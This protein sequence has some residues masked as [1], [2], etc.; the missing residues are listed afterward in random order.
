MGPL[1]SRLPR[2]ARRQGASPAYVLGSWCPASLCTSSAAGGGGSAVG[3][4][5]QAEAARLPRWDPRRHLGPAPS[6]SS[7]HPCSPLPAPRHGPRKNE[8]FSKDRKEGAL[9]ELGEKPV[10]RGSCCGEVRPCPG[11]K[12]SALARAA[13]ANC[14]Q[15]AP[16]AAPSRCAH[17]PRGG[18]RPGSTACSQRSGSRALATGCSLAPPHCQAPPRPE[19]LPRGRSLRPP[20]SP[21]PPRPR[22]RSRPTV[23][24]LASSAQGWNVFPHRPLR[25]QRE[26]PK[27]RQLLAPGAKAKVTR[28]LLGGGVRD[29][30][31]V[32][33]AFLLFLGSFA[34]F[35]PVFYPSGNRVNLREPRGSGEEGKVAVFPDL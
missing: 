5:R 7:A 16:P 28:H 20:S 14:L 11:Y 2:P 35:L 26:A 34:H 23:P 3:K 25:S 17:P 1:S 27:S 21:A 6:R 10:S 31:S 9:R 33:C 19:S 30:P 4:S 8:A 15:R 29:H 24:T 22:P 18:A 32:P 12:R 13:G